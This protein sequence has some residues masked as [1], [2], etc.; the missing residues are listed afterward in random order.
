MGIV[1][2]AFHPALKRTV[3]LKVLIAGEDASEEAIKRF[4]REAEAVAKLGH[5]P[6]I[7][8]VHDIGV[9]GKIHYFAMH[10]VEGKPLDRMID[11]HPI[12]P[13]R[14]AEIAMKL[15][16][17]LHHAHKHGVLHRDVKPA[18]VLMAFTKLEGEPK[19]EIPNPKSQ[20]PTKSQIP[21]LNDTGSGR[22]GRAEGASGESG[23]EPMLTDFGLAKDVESESKMTRS[24]MTLGTPQYMPPEQAKGDLGRVD[25]RSDVYSLGATL[26]EVLTLQAPIE[27]DNVMEVIHKVLFKEAVSPRRRNPAVEPDLETICLKCLEKEPERR[28]AKAATL[29]RDLAN[30][31]D[32]AP[33]AARP[34]S[35]RY[36]VMKKAKRHKALVATAALS[37]LLLVA[38]GI[39]GANYLSRM[40]DV[41]EREVADAQAD[42]NKE[43]VR[44]NEADRL[45][46]KNL[47]VA[48]VLLAMYVNLEEV[49][50]ALKRTFYDSSKSV[51]EKQAFYRQHE[52]NIEAFCESFTIRAS[53]GGGLE[54]GGPPASVDRATLST[55]LAMKAW[56]MHLGSYEEESV[57]LFRQ[58]C[59]ADP[60]VAWGK[61]FEAIVHL[62]H[63]L[64][65]TPTPKAALSGSRLEFE[66]MPEEN[67][68]IRRERKQFETLAK[69]ALRARAWGKEAKDVREVTEGILK[70]GGRESWIVEKAFS[71]ALSLPELKW[72]REELLF[73]RAKSRYLRKDFEGGLKDIN[74]LLK[75]KYEASE[76]FGLKGHLLLAS[77]VRDAWRGKTSWPKFREAAAFFVEAK[78]RRPGDPAAYINCGNTYLSLADAEVDRGLDARESY[79]KA[80]QEYQEALKRNSQDVWARNNCGNAYLHLGNEEAL[81]GIDPQPSYRN[82]IGE[83]DEALKKNPEMV[84]AYSN[85]GV[86]YEAFACAEDSRG[87]DPRPFLR[88]A[89]ADFDEALRRDPEYL[90]AYCFRGSTY[91]TM[92][93]TEFKRGGEPW[94]LHENAL[95]DYGEALK[96]NRECYTAY[97]NRGGAYT[98][99]GRM[100][101]SRGL[102]PRESFRKAIL[103]ATDALKWGPNTFAPFGNRAYAYLLNGEAESSRGLDPRESFRKA[104]LD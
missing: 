48:E 94:A 8:P 31:L 80:I 52:G 56:L 78:K 85:R 103:D 15:A 18:N 98:V 51:E 50:E 60:D 66:K 32:G 63:L 46:E 39:V 86:A 101:A 92:A 67:E 45:R 44:A 75:L 35:L 53:E 65:L 38:A 1:Y 17:A 4:H 47:K 83:F 77:A 24:G 20:I 36:R 25:E 49:H 81:R 73:V 57:A 22:S 82:A 58:A 89:I 54:G 19:S 27:G 100:E 79:R 12:G 34:A 84:I 43:R 28:Y 9:E 74:T 99:L 55:V 37:L 3:A 16:K 76:H 70:I 42:A 95:K 88:K 30:Y 64:L 62:A 33:I 87:A 72:V 14:A 13:K 97:V 23:S 91:L 10:Y 71:K 41:S 40:K 5:H 2:K 93:E 104:I 7:V 61:L 96:R 29:A 68:L 6:N 59:E 102:D 90:D 11:E 21:N 69:E 26:Y